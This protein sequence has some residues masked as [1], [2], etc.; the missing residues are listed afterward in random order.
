VLDERVSPTD[1]SDAT[2]GRA[3]LLAAGF[4]CVALVGVWHHEMWRDEWQAWMLVRDSLSGLRL[5]ELVGH[6]GHFPGWHLLLLVLSRFTRD[7]A[8]MQVA[9]AAI[10]T[11]SVYLLARHA[12]WSWG[13]KVMAAFGYFLAYEY[14]V[15]AR[16]YAL[17]V[18]GL[19]LLCVFYPQRTRR[20]RRT[21]GLVLALG[22][23]ATTSIYGVILAG[24][25]LG[26][27]LVQAATL[28]AATAG[29][30]A[31]RAGARGALLVWAAAVTA[32]A[33]VAL[34]QPPMFL[35][36]APGIS[37]LPLLSRWGLASTAATLSQAYLPLP[38][39]FSAHPWETHALAADT[40]LGLAILL[41]LSLILVAA[42]VLMLLRTPLVLFFYV[43]GT[44]GILLFSHLVFAGF[45]RHH[46]HLYLLFLACLWIAGSE[47]PGWRPPASIDRW[48][49]TGTRWA[50]SLVFVVLAVQLAA[51]GVLYAADLRR[52]F[53]AS[54]EAAAFLRAQGLAD[55]P[56]LASPSPPASS[57]AGILDRPIH[58]LGT[59]EPGTFIDWDRFARRRDRNFSMRLAR[60]FFDARDSDVIVILSAPFQ[61]WDEDLEVEQLARFGPGIERTERFVVYR[62]GGRP[63]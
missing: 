46:G 9:H 56:I 52:P 12:P 32:G 6:E 39:L 51:A 42:S 11:G 29:A 3:A 40:T 16:P 18:L 54:A 33:A 15:V 58:Y 37:E 26:M 41:V 21:W 17:G 45:L 10:A 44:G 28:P 49:G 30:R 13:L 53:S 5:L 38:E 47:T 4:L 43:V 1:P 59:Q 57:I 14:A 7:P 20:T 34:V 61:D 48:A 25:A 36:G 22:L 2:R 31:W 35:R 23:L 24:A 8:A 27:L 19:F 62:V 50:R 60:P 63:R 55:L